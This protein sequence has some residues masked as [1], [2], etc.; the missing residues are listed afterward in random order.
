M[1]FVSFPER[2]RLEDDDERGQP[3]RQ[4][5]EEILIGNG[6]CEVQ[7]MDISALSIISPLLFRPSCFDRVLSTGRVLN[8]LAQ[9]IAGVRTVIATS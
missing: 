8:V 2:E 4:L 7:S 3:H 6:E 5:W 9:A 1:L